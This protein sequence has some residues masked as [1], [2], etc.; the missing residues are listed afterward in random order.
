MPTSEVPGFKFG[1]SSF[2]LVNTA[3]SCPGNSF[4]KIPLDTVTSAHLEEFMKSNSMSS[5]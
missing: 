5:S 2:F 3:V 1:L 4:S